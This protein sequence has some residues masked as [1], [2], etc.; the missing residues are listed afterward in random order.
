LLNSTSIATLFLDTRLCIRRFTPAAVKLFSL[1][2][3]DIG[4]PIADIAQRFTDPALLSDAAAVLER[5]IAPK[6]EVQGHDGRSYVRQVLPYRTHDGRIEGVVITL[7]D[8]AAEALQEARLYAEAIVDTVRDPLLVLDADLRVVSANR[9]FYSE[10]HLAE[11]DTLGRALYELG[12]REWDIPELRNLLAQV[13]A[14][15]RVLS[16]FEMA[17][18]FRALGPR[19][20]L[21]NARALVRGGD[22]PD[23]I[24]LAIED[25]TEYRRLQ[26]ALRETESLKKIEEQV[27]QRQAQL[28]HALRIS[29]VG[30]LASGLAH[31]INQPLS[32]I[33]N[34]V[35]ACARFVRSG[36]VDAKQLLTLLEDASSEAL[37][38]GEIVEHLRHFIR[39]GEPKCERAD[40]VEIARHVP[41]VLGHEIKRE[42]IS[43]LLD[44]QARSLPIYADRIQIEQ[45][46]VNLV[47]NAID[48]IRGV[49]GVDREIELSVGKV[50][51]MAE[52]AVRDK[53]A[54]VPAEDIGRLFE[55]FFTTKQQ[56]LGLGLSISRS[57]I[58]AHHGRIWAD[59]PT[60]D[61][62]G[63][64]IRFTL[65][66]HEPK[67]AK[68]EATA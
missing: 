25:L 4:R 68:K 53:G 48:S 43:L 3:S 14:R 19:I 24:L 30:A 54:G 67:P 26:D 18:D 47:Q 35:E 15:K 56:G 52:V 60:D 65:P 8:V 29:T 34:D 58:E 45:V 27:R 10:F 32:T 37:R 36:D 33:A 46:V 49:R 5:P 40:L 2:P 66:L 44:L 59:R 39:K 6:T 7:S 9:A 55:P 38:A 63:I 64:I 50:R 23:L 57:I 1:I 16:G 12:N 20:L 22:R 51:G 41:R 42:R 11:G 62:P 17:H 13:L 21:L 28:A 31:E 61:G